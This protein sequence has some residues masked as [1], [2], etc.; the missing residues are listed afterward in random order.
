MFKLQICFQLSYQQ[1]QHGAARIVLQEE[2]TASRGPSAVATEQ[3]PR[4]AALINNTNEQAAERKMVIVLFLSFGTAGRKSLTNHYP[5]MRV[6]TIS[7]REMNENCEQA[8]VKPRNRTL[9][10]YIFFP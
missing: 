8:L 2:M 1:L 3:Q 4:V 10:R 5:H 6:A 9:E 7:I